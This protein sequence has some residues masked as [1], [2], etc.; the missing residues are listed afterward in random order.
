MERCEF[1]GEEVG[2][3]ACGCGAAHLV[4]SCACGDQI[5]EDDGECCAGE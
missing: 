5:A 1:C 4:A 3:R 2:Y